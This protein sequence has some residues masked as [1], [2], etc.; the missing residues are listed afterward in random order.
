MFRYGK[1]ARQAVSAIGYLAQHHG[2]G[3]GVV[4]SARV[5]RAR[6]I[7]VA[8]AAKLLSEMASAGL[9]TG[10]SGPK[11]G[12]RLARPPQKIFLGEVVRIFEPAKGD[13]PCPF[14][15]V[16]CGNGPHCPLHDSFVH[17]QSMADAFL[18]RTT[19]AGFAELGPEAGTP[20]AKRTKSSAARP[21]VKEVAKK[22]AGRKNK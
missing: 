9:L 20:T 18:D 14:G 17:M 2:E 11:G 6:G 13:F 8:L 22:P 10:T 15:P 5:A 16:W 7:S 4:S 1:Q 19:L 21:A 12:Y 3:K